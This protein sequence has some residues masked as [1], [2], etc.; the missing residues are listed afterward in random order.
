MYNFCTFNLVKN[1][2]FQNRTFPLRELEFTKYNNVVI[3]TIELNN[4]LMTNTGGF[5]SEEA[6]AIDECIY[7]YVES[8]QLSLSDKQL[9]KLIGKEC[10]A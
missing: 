8:N 3:S 7:Y 5:V 4:L 10:N 6:E 2:K 9:I 1:I